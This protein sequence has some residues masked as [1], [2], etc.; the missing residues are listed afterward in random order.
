MVA[1]I[2]SQEHFR[3]LP[4]IISTNHKKECKE[5]ITALHFMNEE[6]IKVSINSKVE[7]EPKSLWQQRSFTLPQC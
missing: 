1:I 4:Y 6:T 3:Y 7:N 5:G 2:Q